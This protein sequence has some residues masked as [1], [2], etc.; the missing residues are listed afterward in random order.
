MIWELGFFKSIRLKVNMLV[1]LEFQLAYYDVAVQHVN[2]YAMG[3]LSK[4]VMLE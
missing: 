2:R 3:T 4:Q 1:Q